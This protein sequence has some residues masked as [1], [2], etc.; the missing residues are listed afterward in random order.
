M[1]DSVQ[2]GI[3][4]WVVGEKDCV[5]NSRRQ[6]EVGS[7]GNYCHR[8]KLDGAKPRMIREVMRVLSSAISPSASSPTTSKKHD[9]N[10]YQG[11]KQCG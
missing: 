11:N 8:H 5:R 10:Y 4:E 7:V 2:D 6:C 9:H 3:A 1:L